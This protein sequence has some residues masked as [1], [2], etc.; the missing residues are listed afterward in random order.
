MTTEGETATDRGGDYTQALSEQLDRYAVVVLAEAQAARGAFQR[1]VVV[2][3]LKGDGPVVVRLRF[4][5]QPADEGRLQVLFLRPIVAASGEPS[6]EATL[7]PGPNASEDTSTLG[8][9]AVGQPVMYWYQGEAAMAR[10][11]PAGTDPAA[12]NLP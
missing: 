10:E 12:V 8:P 11:L 4:V 1:F 2:K 3:F 9:P 6:V 5:D 7:T